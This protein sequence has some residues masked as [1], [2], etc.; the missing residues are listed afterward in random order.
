MKRGEV[1]FI[2]GGNYLGSEQMPARPGVIIQND[3]G[4]QH[5]RVT[6][7]AYVTNV[8]KKTT[9]PV[10]V[11]TEYGMVMLEQIASVSI[12]RLKQKLGEIDEIKM[13]EIDRAIA[14]SVGLKSLSN[15]SDSIGN[16]TSQQD[17]TVDEIIEII[18]IKMREI[19]NRLNIINTWFKDTENKWL[20]LEAEKIELEKNV[21]KLIKI[22]AL[23]ES[24][25]E[26]E[27]KT[28]IKTEPEARIEIRQGPVPILEEEIKTEKDIPTELL[29]MSKRSIAA[30][31][32][33]EY[34]E[35]A[36]RATI[37]ELAEYAT[38]PLD[39]KTTY[40]AIY[41]MKDKVRLSGDG[42]YELIEKGDIK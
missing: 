11:M 28:E 42:M 36:K 9:L 29:S 2:D 32:I 25:P 35:V 41:M 4:N 5:S 31:N 34:L 15:N 30:R 12:V 23:P 6:I 21:K 39:K 3:I 19:T 26:I 16:A 24:E 38:T 40:N 14:E 7:I 13:M 17:L 33:L 22:N 8:K 18:E 27:I 20:L 1:Y 10:H 37:K